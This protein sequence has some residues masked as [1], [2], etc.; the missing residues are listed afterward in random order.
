MSTGACGI[1]CYVC[2]LNLMGICSTCGSGINR[3][4]QNKMAAQKRILGQPCPILACAIKSHI[5]YCPRDCDRFPCDEFMS[6]PY[7]FSDGYLNMQVRRR[8]EKYSSKTPSGNLVEIPPQHWEDIELRDIEKVCEKASAINRSSTG[9]LLPFLNEYLLVDIR[10]KSLF[11]QSQEGLERIDNPLLGLLC[12]VYL[13]NVS[14]EPLSQ[15]MISVHE[16]KTSHFFKGP[17]E[18]KVRPLLERYGNDLDGF[19]KTAERVG[20]EAI[21][22]ADAGY[23]FSVFP[24]VPLYYLFWEGD[25]EF[26]STLSIL[27]DRSVEHH[28]AADAIWGIV[29][30][31]SDILL[32]GD[33]RALF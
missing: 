6:G 33:I 26:G 22:M 24:K 4:G 29:N 31:M 5:E 20:G 14:S 32:M 2:R 8:N 10:N 15:E 28:I 21:D 9:L 23:K 3:D 27:F 11:R 7:P 16:L 1:N 30:L 25:Q 18:L 13:L 17:H 12:L 19:K